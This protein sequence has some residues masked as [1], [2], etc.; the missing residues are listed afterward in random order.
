MPKLPPTSARRLIRALQRLGFRKHR[1]R[2]TSHLV[3][4]HP[5]GRRTS[6][7]VHPGD[8]PTG[9]LRGIFSDIRITPENLREVL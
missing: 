8:I 9:T 1:Q 6:V 4:V 2:G 5:D 3:M 7:P